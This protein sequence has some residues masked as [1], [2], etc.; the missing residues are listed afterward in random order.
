MSRKK[1]LSGEMKRE[2]ALRAQT[3]KPLKIKEE[4]DRGNAVDFELEEN[5]VP[6]RATR[7]EREVTVWKCLQYDSDLGVRKKLLVRQKGRS[8]QESTVLPYPGSSA[9]C[10]VLENVKASVLPRRRL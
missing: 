3:M 2:S 9:S 8:V 7:H 1:R 10:G 5:N 6:V 4:A